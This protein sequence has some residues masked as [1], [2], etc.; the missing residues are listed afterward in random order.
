MYSVSILLFDKYY[1]KLL[2][3]AYAGAYVCPSGENDLTSSSLHRGGADNVLEA[4]ERILSDQ[5]TKR[6]LN[7]HPSGEYRLHGE[8]ICGEEV[9]EEC[10]IYQMA[11]PRITP[12]LMARNSVS[13]F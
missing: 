10:I 9:V 6:V 12:M 2:C 7:W 1:V 3:R 11:I 8:S 13:I 5:S 4:T